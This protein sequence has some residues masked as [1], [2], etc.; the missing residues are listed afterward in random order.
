[1]FYSNH[2][3]YLNPRHFT[4]VKSVDIGNQLYFIKKCNYPHLYNCDYA[5]KMVENFKVDV[6]VRFTIKSITVLLLA[7]LVVVFFIDTSPEVSMVT[8]SVSITMSILL[9]YVLDWMDDNYPLCWVKPV[10]DEDPSYADNYY[11]L[12]MYTHDSRVDD[13]LR[14]WDIREV[15]PILIDYSYVDRR[16]QPERHEILK[17]TLLNYANEVKGV[18]EIKSR[19]G[20][21]KKSSSDRS[22]LEES[23]S[24]MNSLEERGDVVNGNDSNEG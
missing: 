12:E 21:E 19:E 9:M 23:G 13:V 24:R 15:L 3:K 6:A 18:G 5:I 20:E 8:S 1:M 10:L 22:L 17:K 4:N 16:L 11:S 14:H 2:I 7:A